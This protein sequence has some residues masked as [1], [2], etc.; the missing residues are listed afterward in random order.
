MS[1]SSTYSARDL[2]NAFNARFRVANLAGE[3]M[4][5][6]RYGAPVALSVGAGVRQAA[7]VVFHLTGEVYKREVLDGLTGV[8]SCADSPPEPPASLRW[9]ADPEGMILDLGADEGVVVT[10]AGWAV[11]PLEGSSALFRRPA[12]SKPLPVP[13]RGGSRELLRSHLGV[14]DDAWALM[15]GW[16]VAACFTG[17][18]CALLW[19][20]GEQ[21]A[22]KSTRVEALV[23]VIDPIDKLGADP[24]RSLPDA[25]VAAIARY[26]PTFDN[27]S[28]VSGDTSDWLCRL[29]TGATVEKRALYTDEGLIS[30]SLR[31]AGVAT[32]VV[33]PAGLRN[34][35]L[36]RIA[37]IRLERLSDTDRR[38]E[39]AIR[40]SFAAQHP[41]ILGALL[42]DVSATMRALADG[43]HPPRLPRL[44]TF[45]QVL[46]AL[47]SVT[48]LDAFGAFE[49][50]AQSLLVD[51]AEDDP[52]LAEIARVGSKGWSGTAAELLL[53]LEPPQAHGVWWPTSARQLGAEL[54]ANTQALLAV[55][56]IVTRRRSDGRNMI[57]LR[58]AHAPIPEPPR[59]T[60]P[61]R[62][63]S[64]DVLRSLLGDLDD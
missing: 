47:D 48:Q 44:A 29:V 46:Y 13:T 64:R 18:E 50:S 14:G 21:G 28:K 4:A 35:A 11:R 24:G 40:A 42:D 59:S 5:V 25:G 3:P 34:D 33:I 9:H 20:S 16:L 49:R 56:V 55:G 37:S 52:L 31:R 39:T 19:V 23:S 2:H 41:A 17:R 43:I 53:E 38:T 7:S 58:P 60:P 36:D 61:T 8:L 63:N 51:R 45:G 10:A 22:G 27:L 62:A 1:S 6:P 32:S 12:V 15:Y 30:R 54:T 57:D 26:L